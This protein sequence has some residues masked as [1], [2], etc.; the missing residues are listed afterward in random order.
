MPPNQ[1]KF[2]VVRAG[3][4]GEDEE[5]VLRSSIAMIGFPEV[6]FPIPS[7]KNAIQERMAD[8]HPGKNPSTVSK[9]VGELDTFANKIQDGDFVVLPTK[10][11][12]KGPIAVGTVTGPYEC[13]EIAGKLRHTRRVRWI[14][15]DISRDEFGA[16]VAV[17]HRTMTVFP[18]EK[19]V[20]ERIATILEPEVD[21]KSP[22]VDLK[23]VEGLRRACKQAGATLDS[24]RVRD[25][26]V[27]LKEVQAASLEKRATEQFQI[28]VWTKHLVWRGGWFDASVKSALQD[29]EFRQWF[30]R[31]TTYDLA[32]ERGE[33]TKH[34]SNI[35]DKT[36]ARLKKTAGQNP[37][38]ETLRT[39][40]AFFPGDFTGVAHD[41]KLLA[42]LRAMGMRGTEARPVEANRKILDRLTEVIGPV[43]TSDLDAVA[44][45]LLLGGAL[46]G[47]VQ[48][49]PRNG[50][51]PMPAAARRLGLTLFWGGNG[52][53]A[54]RETID[55]VGNDGISAADLRR[56]LMEKRQSWN[57][58]TANHW[59]QQ[60]I[61]DFECMSREGDTTRLSESGRKLHE[62]GDPDELM[63][64]LLT[65]V[66]GPD[67]IVVSLRAS[68]LSKGELIRTLQ[69]ANPGWKATGPEGLLRWM[70]W[71]DV[72][73]TVADGGYSLTERGARWS[74]AVWWDPERLVLPDAVPRVPSLG[75][76]MRRF[77]D[78]V[79]GEKLRFPEALVESLHLGLWADPQR[80]FAVLAGLSG[81]G[82]T[83]L[84]VQ[85]GKALTGFEGE[86]GGPVEVIA[87]QPGWHD[88]GPLL[89]YVNPL[90]EG[91]YQR[92]KFL[93]FLRATIEKPETPHV[94]V[95]DEMN[96]SHPEQYFAPMLS[97]MERKGGEIELHRGDAD[98]LEVPTGIPYPE[99]LV[100]IGTVN[101]DETTM[102]ISDKVLDRAFTLEFW[103]IVPD[104]WPGWSECALGEAEKSGVGEFLT[105]LTDALRPAQRH[106][107]WRVIAEV[108]GFLELHAREAD[109]KLDATAALD[110]AIYAKVLPK[111]RGDDTPRFRKC[112]EDTHKVL[113]G[114]GI[115]KCARK[116][117]ELQ[118]DLEA[119]GS[120]SFWRRP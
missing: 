50:L 44:K 69:A 92:T 51:K 4:K 115:E 16:D 68:A 94:L 56:G 117:K 17:F 108:V 106:F 82:K 101:M 102:G 41:A 76:V 77:R 64:R 19:I 12:L 48:P 85:Y 14:R 63:D 88:P 89:G 5:F 9:W 53:D 39:L 22:E 35:Y 43:D 93:D 20:A 18:I 10:R 91:A 116:V 75:E 3:G 2:W 29:D 104:E 66:L 96:L 95:L 110:A 99:N 34:L 52:F 36:I 28:D 97:A 74:K 70:Q 25:T 6:T 27:L 55:M 42:L 118:E 98:K 90:A 81:T 72:I 71:L 60:S 40:A 8:T 109:G 61:G 120:A 114:R 37:K 112:L 59:I 46:Y 23:S 57:D 38:L 86:T 73:G 58:S 78:A 83:Q 21:L 79:K 67:H 65:G 26:A 13:R 119:T 30:A 84:A 47:L 111:V 100:I 32:A 103:D 45:R 80:H 33:R 1:P 15:N 87:V 24:K 107:G 105:D 7:D 31:E 54:L 49:V 113:E 62:S 11:K